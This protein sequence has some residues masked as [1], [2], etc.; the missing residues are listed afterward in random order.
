MAVDAV[1]GWTSRVAGITSSLFFGSTSNGPLVTGDTHSVTFVAMFIFTVIA[2]IVAIVV[3]A[4]VLIQSCKTCGSALSILLRWIAFVALVST[5]VVFAALLFH[6]ADAWLEVVLP[7]EF[8]T[9][10]I[11][12]SNDD[13]FG[14]L[15]KIAQSF[16]PRAA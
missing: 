16:R 1:Y 12:E 7:S 14:I 5:G 4:V 15:V 9:R 8:L 11:R 2:G 13:P 3:I 6:L 10:T